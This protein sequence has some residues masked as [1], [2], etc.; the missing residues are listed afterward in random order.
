MTPTARFSPLR[1]LELSLPSGWR[2]TAYSPEIDGVLAQKALDS[3]QPDVAA[4]AARVIGRVRSGHAVNVIAERQRTGDKAALQ[5][6]ALV[7]DE[8][9]SLPASVS[10][11][12]RLYAWLV[13][14]RRRLGENSLSAMWRLLLAALGGVIAMAFYVVRAYTGPGAQV[15][16]AQI[17]GDA[18]AFGLT[19]GVMVGITT[20]FA[21]ELPDRVRGF[22]RLWARVPLAA[23]LGFTFTMLM[24]GLFSYLVLRAEVIDWAVM[25]PAGVGGAVGWGLL[26]AVRLPGWARALVTAA[27]MYIPL[28][29]SFDAYWN[30]GSP[31]I[32][33]FTAYEHVY[34]FLIPMVI[35]I[36]V[37]SHLQAIVC[38]VRWLTARLRA[39]PGDSLPAEM[40]AA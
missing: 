34:E 13:N 29:L 12:A 5:A 10:Q 4:L 3:S 22:W 1:L 18:I 6:L 33:Y 11:Q 38:D 32:F 25:I 9:P 20:L 37:F 31:A 39:K 40:R 23:L 15:I 7:R 28:F 26:A 27:A 24:W 14:T 8:T 35:I 30:T 17:W 19:F 36:G 16:L 2:E 21:S